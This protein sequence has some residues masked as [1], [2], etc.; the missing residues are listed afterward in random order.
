MGVI[1][2]RNGKYVTKSEHEANMLRAMSLKTPYMDDNLEQS[3]AQPAQEQQQ[4]A[5]VEG[6]ITAYDVRNKKKGVVMQDAV[7]TKTAKGA[8]MAQGH[9]GEGGKLTTLLNG[10]KAMAAIKAGTAKQGWKD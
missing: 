6:Q 3:A 8:Y 7:I 1:I 10:E 2:F 9:N 5:A 4:P